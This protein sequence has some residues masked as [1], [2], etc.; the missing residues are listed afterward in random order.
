MHKENVLLA[1]QPIY[2][3]ELGIYAYELLFRSDNN[4][5]VEDVDADEATSAVIFNTFS[6]I[7][8][9]NVVGEHLAFINFT[10]NLLLEP[11]PFTSS[12]MVIEVLEDVTPDA[13]V[14]RSIKNLKQQGFIIALDD[15]EYNESLQPL[16]DLADIIK[17]DVMALSEQQITEHVTQLKKSSVKLLA[18]KVE[19]QD[20]YNFCKTLD[21]DYFQGYFLSRPK[22]M[23]G[24]KVPANK[25]VVMKLI[26]DLQ[27]PDS[28]PQQL[29]DTISKDPSLSFKL[30]KMINSAAYRRPN[31]I[32]SL[33]RAVVL[34]GEKDIRHWA[35]LLAM[36]QLDDKPHALT[37]LTMVRAKMCELLGTHIHKQQRDLFFTVGMLSMMDA[38]FD[39]PMEELLESMDLTDEMN[40]ALTNH[41][42]IL[43]F[44]LKTSIT[45]EQ[46]DWGHIQWDALTQHHLSISDV[47]QAYL[48][49]LQWC[50]ERTESL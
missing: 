16:V 33:F 43:G 25:M 13:D 14:I 12:E 8:I 7:G 38:Y 31:K 26:A 29:H 19:T 39:A 15:F 47:K 22:I 46:G 18:E 42:G 40:D 41:E 50:H 49:S 3:T 21:F 28:D 34:L 37:E 32:D 44:V 1:R 5:R 30:L 4:L 11:P 6:E 2:N 35:S 36:S 23:K 20:M 10:R 24:R 17:I 9:H 27:S 45:Y 48:D